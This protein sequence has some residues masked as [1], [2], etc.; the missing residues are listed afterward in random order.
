[1][2]RFLAGVTLSLLVALSA[3]A[4]APKL[5]FSAAQTVAEGGKG[6]FHGSYYQDENDLYFFTLGRPGKPS[7]LHHF[8]GPSMNY[9]G[10][11]L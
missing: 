7:H 11:K 8:Q 6:N 3:L 1:M 2:I 5:K 9:V 4:Q 10:T